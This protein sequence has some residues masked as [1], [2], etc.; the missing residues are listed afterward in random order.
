[1]DVREGSLRIVCEDP[2]QQATRQG[3]LIEAVH[4]LALAGDSVVEMPP[5]RWPGFFQRHIPGVADSIRKCEETSAFLEK[6]LKRVKERLVEQGLDF[7]NPIRGREIVEQN[8]ISF[9]PAP[10]FGLSRERLM[11]CI[12]PRYTGIG[13]LF[14]HLK[15]NTSSKPI[16]V[17][18][19]DVS[20]DSSTVEKGVYASVGELIF[21]ETLRVMVANKCLLGCPMRWVPWAGGKYDR[22]LNDG[23]CCGLQDGLMRLWETGKKAGLPE[24][25]WRKPIACPP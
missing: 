20:T 4:K 10:S 24:Q 1:V 22:L 8:G 13:I 14:T 12:E 6:E 5:D 21:F 3:R 17:P 15:T 19:M 9:C 23:E 2:L 7:A 16:L 25:T 11:L 18:F